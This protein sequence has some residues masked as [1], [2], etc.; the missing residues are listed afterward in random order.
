MIIPI[1]T[2][3]C[4]LVPLYCIYK[5][6]ALLIRYFQH[7]WP[8]VLFH[9]PLPSSSSSPKKLVALTIDDGPSAYTADILH[10]LQ[11]HDATATFFLIGS[12]IPGYE[13]ILRDLVRARNELANHAMHDEPSRALSDA[14]LTEQIAAVQ[15]KIEEAY[16]SAGDETEGRPR[17]WLFRP[18]SGFF[19]ERMRKV[20]ARLG[21]RLVLGNVYPHDPQVPFWRLNA[22]H[23]LSMVKP[24]SIIVC[25]DRREW[26]VPM[27]QRVLPELKRR[28]YQVVTVTELLEAGSSSA[29]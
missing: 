16:K 25:H 15:A 9:V 24:G 17:N 7:R 28:G 29:R 18:G 11:S 12:Q 5:P 6:P 23:I 4:L 14:V 21:Y 22:S 3:F 8:D 1:L 2:S 27:L 19:S 20:V 13:A 10:L 26:T